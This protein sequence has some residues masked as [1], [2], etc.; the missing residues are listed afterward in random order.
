MQNLNKALKKWEGIPRE[1]YFLENQRLADSTW[2]REL[3]PTVADIAEFISGEKNEQM[4]AIFDFFE[5]ENDF[6]AMAYRQGE[7]YSESESQKFIQSVMSSNNT[8][9]SE[10]GY[11]YKLLMASADD[12]I[13]VENDCGCDGVLWKLDEITPAV[14]AYRIK[15]SWIN[16]L[17]KYARFGFDTFIQECKKK[18]L[19]HVHVRVWIAKSR[20][21]RP[22]ANAE[23]PH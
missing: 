12:F 22:R 16:E 5:N 7:T 14:Y 9:I 6:H 23:R 13:I 1:E 8:D 15:W 20:F 11:F 10:A 4:S 18:S 3:I 21:V 2:E 19:D 17:K